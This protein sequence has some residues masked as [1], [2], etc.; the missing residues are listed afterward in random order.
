[1][2]FRIGG[3]ND[4]AHATPTSLDRRTRLRSSIESLMRY[5]SESGA[6]VASP[7]FSQYSFCWLR[8]ASFVAYALDR[9]GEH[10]SS[11]RYHEWV[12]A[13]I[14]AGGIG[15]EI[16]AAVDKRSAQV[17]LNPNEMPPAR[18]SLD[19]RVVAD[20]WP[21]FQIDG[22]GTWLWA[23]REH[24]ALSG[25]AD[26][27]LQLR[28][29][30]ERVGRYLSAFAFQPCFDVWE[31]NGDEVHTSTLS[32]VYAG[33]VAAAHLLADEELRRCAQSVADYIREDATKIGR[34]RKSNAQSDVD[35]SL[36]WLSVPFGVC[37]P[38]DPLFLATVR[39][40]EGRLSFAGGIR[41]YAA[42]TFFGGGAWPVLTCSLGWHYARTG[43]PED[44]KR[45]LDW[46]GSHRDNAG[47]LG[48]QF[49]GEIRDP[50]HYQ[51]WVGRWGPPA[52]DL[53][54]SHAMYVILAAE[55][56]QGSPS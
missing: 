43:R 7:D 38:D 26:L 54:W 1:M 17:S 41:R 31:E 51:E 20:D 40:I 33:L 21:N 32:S 30:V 48:E 44:A 16:D 36:L 2:S 25:I 27:P 46:A 19:G 29:T 18:F 52:R 45:C 39:D 42:D 34:Y 14:G 10:A 22:Y 50:A 9:A 5:Q 55:I 56:E 49:G 3:G 53:L 28:E 4:V 47:R 8:D 37:D 12:D 6:L 15:S 13:A 11:R 24:L 35:A 23:L